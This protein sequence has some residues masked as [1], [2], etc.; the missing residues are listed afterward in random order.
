[1]ARKLLDL[2]QD[3]RAVLEALPQEPLAWDVPDLAEELFGQTDSQ[4]LSRVK[5]ALAGLQDLLFIRNENTRPYG[6]KDSYGIRADRWREVQEMFLASA[7]PEA[8]Q[9]SP[10][11]ETGH[12]LEPA[13]VSA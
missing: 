5:Q 2:S 1:M 13:Q 7:K 9:E 3:E 10:C 11:V 12:S 8:K 6:R 4:A